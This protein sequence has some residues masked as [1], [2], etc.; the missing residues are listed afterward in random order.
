MHRAILGLEYGDRK[1]VVDHANHD[2]LDNRRSNIRIASVSQNNHNTSRK[3]KTGFKGVSYRSDIN[4][5]MAKI[6]INRKY[7]YLGYFST[8]QEAHEA[9]CKASIIYFGT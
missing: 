5:W 1:R 3:N 7:F 4:K 8:P 6:G 2:T 9:Y